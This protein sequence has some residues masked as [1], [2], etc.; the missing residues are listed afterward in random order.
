[1]GVFSLIQLK[2]FNVLSAKFTEEWIPELEI[3]TDLKRSIHEHRLLAERR[4]QTRDFRQLLVVNERLQKASSDIETA[5]KTY[6]E[7][8]KMNHGTA[9]IESFSSQWKQYEKS[10][11]RVDELQNRGEIDHATQLFMQETLPLFH[12]SV[13]IVEELLEITRNA[14]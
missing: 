1:M 4:N 13:H 9:Q 2:E 14:G 10:V 3:V 11:G 6:V 5:L 8:D 12:A 7:T